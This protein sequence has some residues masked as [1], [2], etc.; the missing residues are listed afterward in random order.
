V[1]LRFVRNR[2]AMIGGGARGAAFGAGR[3][4]RGEGRQRVLVGATVAGT[5][6]AAGAT[7]VAAD[8]GAELD[9]TFDG[10]SGVA[11]G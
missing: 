4:E 11:V 8:G 7:S 2:A 5:R 1:W 9:V 6:V 3:G 10:A